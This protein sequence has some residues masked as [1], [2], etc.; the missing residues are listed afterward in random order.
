MSRSASPPASAGKPRKSP[1]RI[2]AAA[3]PTFPARREQ[4]ALPYT[5]VDALRGWKLPT[6]HSDLRAYVRIVPDGQ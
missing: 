6:R 3:E 4:S 2:A 1:L 5:A